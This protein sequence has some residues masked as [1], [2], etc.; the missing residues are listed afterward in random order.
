M[1]GLYTKYN[2]SEDG[3]NAT[4]ALQKLYGPQ[5]QE[6]V[7]LFAFSERLKSTISDNE[8]Y[9]LLNDPFT[10]TNGNTVL[11]TKFVTDRFTFSENNLVWFDKAN[12]INPVIV[13]DAGTIVNL[14][15]EGIGSQYEA[16]TPS[17]TELSYPATVQ[18]RLL[19]LQSGSSD[20]IASVTV[21]SDGTLSRVI[22]VVNG[23]TGYVPGEVL[24]L[25]PSCYPEDNP[26]EDKCLRYT[27][28]SLYH[29]YSDNGEIGYD[30]LIRNERYLYTVKSASSG[31]FFLYDDNEQEWV[32]LGEVYDSFQFTSATSISLNRLDTITSSN[33]TQ[34]Y[35]LDG[36]SLFF[37]YDEGYEPGTGLSSNLRSISNSIE[38][39]KSD[40]PSFVQNVKLQSDDNELGFTYN[41]FVGLNIQSDYRVIFRDPDSVIDDSELDFFELRD[42]TN[43][44]GQVSINGISIPGIWLFTG[45]KYQRVFSTDDKPF[46]SQSGRSYLSPVLTQFDG[47]GGLETA[48]SKLYSIS[49]GYYKPGTALSSSSVRG[50]NTQLGTLVQN[51]SDVGKDGGFVYYRTLAVQENIRGIVDSWPLFSYVDEDGT[52]KDAKILAI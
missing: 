20:A 40:L 9:G 50:F 46:F 27:A 51:L 33:L 21:N 1:S 31:G 47:S 34:L 19:G 5:I 28:N 7:N 2:L 37:N 14:S 41:K 42:E 25:I 3:L 8:V 35:K 43:Q 39:I 23:G 15:V 4:D 30:A 44:A 13:S 38:T 52:V 22:S 11:R 48:T 18:V 24:R 6:D 36:R 17:G 45:E 29:V 49:A 26:V 32:Y 10:D 16:K 12:G